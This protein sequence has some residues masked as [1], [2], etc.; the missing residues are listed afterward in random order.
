MIKRFHVG[1][2]VSSALEWSDAESIGHLEHITIDG[3]TP[4][5]AELRE[6]LERLKLQGVE[7]IPVGEECSEWD[8]KTGCRGHEVIK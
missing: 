8:Y 2:R 1:L 7:V 3:R 6:E 5:V 4:T